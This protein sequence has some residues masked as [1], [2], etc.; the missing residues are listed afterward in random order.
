MPGNQNVQIL[1]FEIQ[2]H[3]GANPQPVT[4]FN[5]GAKG[6]LPTQIS[7]AKMYFTGQND[8]FSTGTQYGTTVAA[9]TANAF[10]FTGTG[11]ELVH[12]LNY[13]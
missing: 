11:F 4:A 2:A 6:T 12:G 7:G 9:P 5:I 10:N 1:R 8:V 13:F 3:G